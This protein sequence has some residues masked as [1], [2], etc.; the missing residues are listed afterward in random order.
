MHLIAECPEELHFG[1][2]QGCNIFSSLLIGPRGREGSNSSSSSGGSRTQ[3]FHQPDETGPIPL[4]HPLTIRRIVQVYSLATGRLVNQRSEHHSEGAEHIRYRRIALQAGIMRPTF[5]PTSSVS[6]LMAGGER[7]EKEKDSPNSGSLMMMEDY[8]MGPVHGAVQRWDEAV[9]A[10]DG[11]AQHLMIGH[12][13]W[14]VAARLQSAYEQEQANKKTKTSGETEGAPE[15][16][17]ET[18]IL[19]LPPGRIELVPSVSRRYESTRN[20]EEASS[21]ATRGSSP[22]QSVMTME[23]ERSLSP[24]HTAVSGTVG[25]QRQQ[26]ASRESTPRSHEAREE[27]Q[28]AHVPVS[29]NHAVSSQQELPQV[30]SEVE[31]SRQVASATLAHM[32]PGDPLHT[33]LSAV[34]GGPCP[35]VLPPSSRTVG[36]TTSGAAA[37][38][39]DL[40]RE[41]STSSSS[42][43]DTLG[44]L[45]TSSLTV[46]STNTLTTVSASGVQPIP[47][48]NV[49]SK[50]EDEM[51]VVPRGGHEVA[52]SSSEQGAVGPSAGPESSDQQSADQA[53]TASEGEA[54]Q[55]SRDEGQGTVEGGEQR[56]QGEPQEA[57]QPSA[58]AV[59]GSSGTEGAP[60]EIDPTFLAA[61]PSDL[62]QEVL[63]QHRVVRERHSAQEGAGE[64]SG[65]E[66]GDAL[67]P[68]SIDQGVLAQLPPEIQAE[69][70]Q[71]LRLIAITAS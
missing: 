24:P 65:A 30:P 38:G 50:H 47:T 57:G 45:L 11:I 12:A 17:K 2:D 33:F 61:L 43:S 53:G 49:E 40:E 44:P 67:R 70:G 39:G 18:N 10:M 63:A 14:E 35:P 41:E 6:Q 48:S 59:A 16:S 1:C 26:P 21:V 29:P 42:P 36:S 5:N 9:N 60:E 19:A 15:E 31:G 68:G 25:E 71:L 34:A 3:R 69:V 52:G 55:P 56:S 8:E 13:M 64:P 20:I 54:S 66:S 23:S 7:Q 32:E 46:S 58:R 28:E 51:E 37:T 27:T 62:R 4:V 22:T